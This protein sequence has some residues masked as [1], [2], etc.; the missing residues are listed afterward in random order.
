MSNENTVNIQELVNDHVSVEAGVATV[1][2]EGIDAALLA[3]DVDPKEYRR[4]QKA[5]ATA[6]AGIVD[7]IGEKAIDAMAADKNLANVSGNFKLGH[8]E[9]NVGIA[10]EATIRIPGKTGEEANKQVIGSTTVRRKTKV[11][12]SGIGEAKKRIAA[13]GIQKLG[14]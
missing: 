4:L 13:L 3:V 2:Q 14:K 11:G 9:Y 8:E 7:S 6:A 5:A 12:N 10:R 1:N